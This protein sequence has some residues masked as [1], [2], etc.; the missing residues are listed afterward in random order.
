MKSFIAHIIYRIVCETV[1]SE[2]YEEQWRIL[3]TN[4]EEE[5]LDE[6]RRLGKEEETCFVD[7]HGRS[8]CWEMIAVKELHEVN[9]KHGAVISSSVKEVEPI[10]APVWTKEYQA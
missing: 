3:F 1:T 9:L 5:A 4:T 6:A 7:R 2:Q 10:A 8:I